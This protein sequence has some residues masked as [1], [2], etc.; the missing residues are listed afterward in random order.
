MTFGTQDIDFI[1]YLLAD[2]AAK[3][4]MPRFRRLAIGDVRQKTSASDLVTEADLAVEYVLY[5]GLQGRFPGAHIVGE[6]AA[7]ANSRL[8]ENQQSD[9]LVF[10]VDP[11]DGTFNFASGVPVFGVMVGVVQ[12]GETVAG[13]IHDPV[14][15]DWVIA[16][17][18][19][20]ARLRSVRGEEQTLS[21][22]SPVPIEK[23]I[24]SVSWQFAP[25][26]ERSMLTRNHARFLAPVAYRC[27]A[28]EY[29]LLASGNI[30]FAYYRKLMPWDHLAGSLIYA[31][32]GGFVRRADGS[33]YRP[34]DIDGGLIAATDPDSWQA[35]RN[36]LFSPA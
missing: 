24:G 26:P 27:A 8:L 36:A 34:Q 6:E 16:E 11:L 19:G 10:Y 3:E 32:A 17:K 7:S 12:D 23:M 25:E 35:I 21:A 13:I 1:A 14:G 15:N 4:I 20:G 31:E 28:Q 29:R 9:G 33:E 5:K 30:H 22:A 2:A 18:G